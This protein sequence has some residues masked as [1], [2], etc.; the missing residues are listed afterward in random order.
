[1]NADLIAVGT[2]LLLGQIVNT[3]ARY[4]AEKLA[5]IGINV[6]YQTVVGDNPTRLLKTLAIASERA[7]LVITTGGLGP[8]GDDLTKEVLAQ[9]LNLPLEINPEELA[10]LKVHFA[11]R[12]LTWVENNAK[13]AAF[14]PGA[15]ILKNDRGTAPGLALKQN[16]KAYIG[17]A[18][19]NGIHVL[20]I[21]H[22]L[23]A[24]ELFGSR[25]Y[26]SAFQGP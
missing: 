13:Q 12:G 15:Y 11:R 26:R 24:G 22:T 2:E 25:K 20:Y 6:Y 3:N 5:E 23:A 21:C 18:Q 19:R 1:M 9:Y 7:D 4:L 8:T 17:T 10:K 16:G 14:P